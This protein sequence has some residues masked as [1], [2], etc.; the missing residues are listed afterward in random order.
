MSA[1]QHHRFKLPS[2]SEVSRSLLATVFGGWYCWVICTIDY[3]LGTNQMIRFISDW[4]TIK[5]W[6]PMLT[7]FEVNMQN[8]S[9][10]QGHWQPLP[11]G[12]I[13]A[14]NREI[15]SRCPKGRGC[16]CPCFGLQFCIL[17]EKRVNRG[18]HCYCNSIWTL[19]CGNSN[20][21]KQSSTRSAQ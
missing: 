7:R 20:M 13:E 4:I 11:F 19:S 1:T 14:Q 10:K 12:R 5:Q 8:W 21:C 6:R 18:R 9:P 2:A 15:D 17:A 3:L 16:Q